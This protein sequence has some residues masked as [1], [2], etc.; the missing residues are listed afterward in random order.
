MS[1]AASPRLKRN[2]RGSVA[3]NG[4]VHDRYRVDPQHADRRHRDVDR[5]RVQRHGGRHVLGTHQCRGAAALHRF[6]GRHPELRRLY[7]RRAGAHDHRFIVQ[8]T[9]SFVPALLF[10]ATLGLSCA[11]VYVFMVPNKPMDVAA[12]GTTEPAIAV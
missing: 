5:S 10:S 2:Q 7:R 8:D 11:L 12:F 4:G 6:V 1:V 3:L 9:G